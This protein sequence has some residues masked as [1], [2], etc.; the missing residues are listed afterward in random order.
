MAE[1]SDWSKDIKVNQRRPG[2]LIVSKMG[3]WHLPYRE[4]SDSMDQ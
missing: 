3:S 4:I 2:M 1:E